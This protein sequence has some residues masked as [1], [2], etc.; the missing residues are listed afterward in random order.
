MATRVVGLTFS[1]T[2]TPT[3]STTPAYTA[4]DNIGGVMSFTNMCSRQ[5][6]TFTIQNV[7]IIDSSKQKSAIDILF[8]TATVTATDNAL[9]N[10]S[11]AQMLTCVGGVSI[12]TGDYIDTSAQSIA[13]VRNIGLSIG[14][15]VSAPT[16]ANTP[17]TKNTTLFAAM[18]A[19][20]TPTYA[21][22][23]ALQV[24][25]NAFVD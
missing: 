17:E 2:V 15:G 13:T 24:T 18:I 7:Q 9:F 16:Q 12:G 11:G 22:T 19:R 10:P 4:T 8:F 1:K 3:V 14:L 20:G 25:I 6:G 21:T 23:S 5:Q